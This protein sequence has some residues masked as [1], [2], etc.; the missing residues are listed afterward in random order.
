VRRA[1]ALLVALGALGEIGAQAVNSWR[2]P[3]DAEWNAAAAYVRARHQPGD[4]IVFAPAWVDPVGRL[5]LGDLVP[6]EEAARPDRSRQA[7]IWEVSIRGAEHPEAR[8]RVAE[9]RVFG[10]VRVRRIERRAAQVLYDFG[11]A[12]PERR[13]VGEVGFLPYLCI[14][15]AP[16][17]TLDFPDVPLGGRIALGGGIHD[18]QSRY[19]SDAPVTLEV[20]L[21]GK[22]VASERFGNDGWRRAA[23]D[24][25]RFAGRRA[26]VRFRVTAERPLA[27]T[28][29]FHAE[30]HR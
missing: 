3:S 8:G 27:R 21:D 24:T 19:Q 5:H 17:D 13:R 12:V 7:R 4:G 11:D 18:F 16:G 2:V 22:R 23:I 26:A 30:V 28:F 1:L 9:S 20:W 14:H 29:C 10:R 15:A 25:A 6:V